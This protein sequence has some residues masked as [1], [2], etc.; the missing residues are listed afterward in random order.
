MTEHPHGHLQNP[1][2]A[3]ME[4]E[5]MVRLART[6]LR[7]GGE[8][9]Q[10]RR[11]ER[12][13]QRAADLASRRGKERVHAPL[14]RISTHRKPRDC[15]RDA[16]DGDERTGYKQAIPDLVGRR[17]I[18]GHLG[19]FAEDALAPARGGCRLKHARDPEDQDGQRVPAAM[20]CLLVCE[21][22][23]KLTRSDDPAERVR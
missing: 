22:G 2:D 7:G 23:A 11:G 6:E 12:Q 5:K 10:A 8:Y 1:F 19:R 20:V 13:G 9:E 17:R 16:G 18:G 3:L 14:D 15:N 21:R 4:A